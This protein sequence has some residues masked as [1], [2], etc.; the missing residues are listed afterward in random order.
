MPSIE[1]E[2]DRCGKCAHEDVCSKKV[3]RDNLQNQIKD[4]LGLMENQTF[5]AKVSC[6]HFLKKG[7]GQV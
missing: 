4:L 3:N 2:G 5:Y 6:K 1:L 7:D